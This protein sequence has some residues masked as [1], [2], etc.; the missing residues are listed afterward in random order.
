MSVGLCV[1]YK[2]Q[3]TDDLFYSL[4]LL[5]LLLQW[6]TKKS[7][8]SSDIFGGLQNQ[9]I[10]CTRV[11][12]WHCL[13]RGD[14][15][16]GTKTKSWMKINISEGLR[17]N[18]KCFPYWQTNLR[19]VCIVTEEFFWWWKCSII[20]GILGSCYLLLPYL[21]IYACMYSFLRIPV[22]EFCFHY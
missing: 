10:L 9:L 11:E 4:L 18:Q 7:M 21:L 5:P 22:T 6:H 17:A 16:L 14:V 2:L 19:L 1:W 20:D 8:Q 15:A 12:C 13:T 3:I